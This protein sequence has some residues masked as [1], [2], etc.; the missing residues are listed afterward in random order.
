MIQNGFWAQDA[1]AAAAAFRQAFPAAVRETLQLADMICQHSFLFKEHWEMERTHVP[2]DFKGPIDWELI[3]DHDP[4]WMYAFNRHS[5]GCTLAKAWLY[6]KDKKYPQTFADLLLDWIKQAPFTEKSKQTTWRSIETGLRCENWLRALFLFGDSVSSDKEFMVAFHTS[7]RQHAAWLLEADTPFQKLSNWGILQN[8][9]LFLLGLYLE[10]PDWCTIAIQRLEEEVHMQFMA[11]GTHWEQSPLYHCEVLHC[12]LDT[13]LAARR[14]N[15]PINNSFSDKIKEAAYGLAYWLRPDGLLICQSDSDEI[16]ARDL[17]VLSAC[18]FH[19]PLLKQYAGN[20]FYEDNFWDIPEMRE[21]Y[22]SI[23]S[24]PKPGSIALK[25]S[26]NYMLWDGIDH[27]SAFLH[28]HCGCLGSGHGHADLLHVDLTAYGETILADSGRYTYVDSPMRKYLKSPAAHNTIIVDQKDFSTY[29]S[30]WCYHPIAEPLKGEHRFTP[31]ADYISGSHLG[32]LPEGVLLN[33]KVLRIDKGL[34]IIWDTGH[35]AD[36]NTPHE[37]KRYFHFGSHGKAALL[38]DG[39]LYQGKNCHAS[40]VLPAENTLHTKAVMPLSTEYNLLTESDC[41]IESIKTKDFLSL[42]A[43][44]AVSDSNSSPHLQ[45]KLIPV[46]LK[47]AGTLLSDA[48][49]QAMQIL[50]NDREWVLI[51]VHHEVICQ[52]DLLSAGG[53]SGYGKTILFGEPCCDGLCLAW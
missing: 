47:Q 25:D 39:A 1:D 15:Y 44:I 43:V 32:Y 29:Q 46:S 16:D 22:F 26:G 3:P 36:P 41:I 13:L 30:S 34:F 23:A 21:E 27:N 24:T 18:L 4:E 2:V 51:M 50:H 19:D 38:P 33:R 5:F 48:D 52:V 7:L 28:M 31:L 10:Q 9:G 53:Y 12:L 45:A 49:A 20:D 37:Y 14:S 35:A 42:P 11:D 40:L 8:H 6:T 17:L